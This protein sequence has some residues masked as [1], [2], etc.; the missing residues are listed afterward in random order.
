MSVLPLPRWVI[1]TRKAILWVG[2][3]WPVTVILLTS[4]FAKRGGGDWAI[5]GVL[6]LATIFAPV[7]LVVSLILP[8]YK[9]RIMAVPPL[10]LALYWI[11]S[12]GSRVAPYM[13][14]WITTFTAI[15]LLI[16]QHSTMELFVRRLFARRA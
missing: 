16:P 9:A 7:T 14:L 12:N 4:L 1:R 11:V 13:L 10:L 3:G 15:G 2:F 5:I 6:F 8:T